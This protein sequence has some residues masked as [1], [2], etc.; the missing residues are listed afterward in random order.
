MVCAAFG[1][2]APAA[3]GATFTVNTTADT[4]DAG[5]CTTAS[6]C[7][8]RDAVVAAD[9]AP[10]SAINLPA[11]HYTLNTGASPLGQLDLTAATTIAGAGARTTIVDGN[12]MSRVFDFEPSAVADVLTLEDLTVTGGAA[13]VTALTITDPGD[14]GGI[15]S[16]GGL[17]L[18]RV[19]VT[20][21][22]AALGGGGIMDGTIH[23]TTPGPATFNEVTIADNKVQG[24]AGNGQGGG[25]VV[26]T[27]LTMT[28][29]T[30]A[31]NEVDNT[32][33]N[34]GGGLV[35]SLAEETSGAS[36]TLVNDTIVGNMAT[37]PVATPAGDLGGG[38]S[39]DQLV[40]G[41]PFDSELNATN[42][43]VADNTADGVEQDCALIDTTDG[44]SSH[45][46]G[47]DSTCGFSD[48]ASKQTT[49]IDL[50]TLKD[51]GGPTDTLVPTSTTAPEVNAGTSTGCP[52]TD[53]R[54]VTRP[55]GSACDIGAV[56]LAPPTATTG[57]ASVV[58]PTG[59]TL[60]GTAGNPAVLA[61]T[62]TFDFGTTTSYGHTASAGSASADSS[63]AP[64][65]AGATALTPNTTYHYRLTV[66]TTDGTAIGAD[67]TFKTPAAPTTTSVSCTPRSLQP[68]HSAAC[69]AKVGNSGSGVTTTPAG[70]VRF[71]Y[72]GGSG[73]C[74]LASGHCAVK[75]TVR[76]PVG[77]RKVTASYGGDSIHA[78]SNG[79]TKIAVLGGCPPTTG[80]VSGTRL[81]AAQLG[82]TRAAER[83]RFHGYSTRGRRQFDFFCAADHHGIRVGYASGRAVL[84]LTSNHYYHLGAVHAGGKLSA[85][86]RDL[87]IYA[88]FTLGLND[89]Y[90][91]KGRSATGVLK[92][93]H[94]Q[95]QE[96]GIAIRSRTRTKQ[97]ARH[98]FANIP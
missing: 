96:I 91:A 42:T 60:S 6:V 70:T 37:E 23:S 15:F 67:Q 78:P 52:A 28:N 94:G 69:T 44:V 48:S 50:G 66:T 18:E 25:A 84:I 33:V 86:M 71:S 4:S 22:T 30:I 45:N 14:G 80:S 27:T 49:A 36:A 89:W 39:G 29:S 31:S 12:G 41:G 7:S 9:A 11:G 54:G 13:P 35:N 53:Q 1:A 55:K 98:L 93:R 75:V 88:H 19:A 34:E 3:L 72:S 64:V 65:S 40:T 97:A 82:L 47:G 81:G 85:A 8:L 74:I 16:N 20:G 26:A 63:T 61:G 46:I 95:V 92:V 24:G 51:N 62:A 2:G 90:L 68:G 43:I 77:S 58:T 59:A 17:D 5:G 87:H 21:N 56:E 57:A 32:G 83:K 79:S 73:H 10:G 76:G 38:I